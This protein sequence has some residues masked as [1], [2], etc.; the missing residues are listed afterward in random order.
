MRPFVSA[1]GVARLLACA[2]LAARA[3]G[4]PPDV[5]WEHLRPHPRLFFNSDTWPGIRA[6][7]LGPQRGW[8]NLL[9]EHADHPRAKNPPRADQGELAAEAALVFMVE[10]NPEYLRRAKAVLEQTVAF[11]RDC[12]RN[13]KAVSWY[14][15]SRIWAL[16]AYDWLHPHLTPEERSRLGRDLLDHVAAVQPAPGQRDPPGRNTSSYESGFYGT[17]CLL[18]YAGLAV[19]GEGIDDPRARDFAEKGHALHVKLLEHRRRA[20]GDDGGSASPALNYALVAYPWAE[21]NFFHTYRSAFGRDVASEWPHVAL[22]ANYALWNRLPGDRW[23]GSGDAYH[24]EEDDAIPPGEML[25]HLDHIRYFF[26][27]TQPLSAALAHQ[28]RDRLPVRDYRWRWPMHAVCHPFLLAGLHDTSSAA[29]PLPRL[30]PA[31]HFENMGQVFMRSGSGDDDTYA[32]FTAGGVV[33]HH[34]HFDENNF[35]IYHKGFLALDSGSRPVPGSHLFQYYCRTIA[36]NCILIR[37]EGETFPRYWGTRAE[38]EPNLPPPNDGG[39]NRAIGARVVAFEARPEYTYVAS[40]AAPCYD[41]R[42]CKQVLRQFLFVP[43]AHFVI[44]DRVVST[45]PDYPKTWLL[46]TAREPAI[47]GDTFSTEQGQGRLFARV[48][49]PLPGAAR[50]RKVGGA[51]MQFW[52]DGRN[53]PIPEGFRVRNDDELVGQWRVE[54]SPQQGRVEDEFLHLLEVGDRQ[55]LLAMTPSQRI[56]TEGKTGVEFDSGDRRVSVLFARQGPPAGSLRIRRATADA[57]W[58]LS[59]SVQEQAGIDGM[60]P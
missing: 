29:L 9:K 22:L 54:V 56:E 18:W 15:F 3:W 24:R 2:L 42:K 8:F 60:A 48:L 46:H 40:D 49:L 26:G 33:N 45:S 39:M 12:D 50:I 36:H 31:R 52:S 21:F 10:G 6:A 44:Y 27:A 55:R 37:M 34:K 4:A 57:A 41:P 17:P 16:A 47:E 25:Y 1:R 30:P 38:G 20:A 32:L 23:F 28:L 14:A 53:W 13:Q 5:P 19:A 59:R 51:G 35:V 7:A 11:Y 43:P 58:E